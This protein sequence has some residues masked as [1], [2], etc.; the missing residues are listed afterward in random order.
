MEEKEQYK[1]LMS[2]VIQKQSIILG[3]EMAISRA[4]GVDG[5]SLSDDGKVADIQGDP[6]AI[7]EKLIDQYVE[8]SGLIV[9]NALSSVFLKY[10]TIK[11]I[12]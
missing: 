5:L 10:P 11:K 8:L 9:K 3:P 6:Q 7:L 1:A 2:E 12:D 4:K